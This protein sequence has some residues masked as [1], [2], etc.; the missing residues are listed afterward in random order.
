M[1]IY[2]YIYVCMYTYIYISF[3]AHIYIYIHVY[4]YIYAH[5]YIYEALKKGAQFRELPIL[6][7]LPPP[8]QARLGRGKAPEEDGWGLWGFR[9]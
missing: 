4:I 8:P 6:S 3:Y 9:V 7:F 1:Y 2:I 5:I